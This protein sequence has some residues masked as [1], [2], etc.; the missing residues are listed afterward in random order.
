M[1][2][3]S[4]S[5]DRVTPSLASRKKKVKFSKPTS[6]PEISHGT[7]HTTAAGKPEALS[8]EANLFY[9]LREKAPSPPSNPLEAK[10]KSIRGRTPEDPTHP[11]GVFPLSGH[12]Q[13]TTSPSSPEKEEGE[14]TPSDADTPTVLLEHYWTLYRRSGLGVNSQLR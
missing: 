6:A 10:G 9:V 12:E 13:V 14:V 5:I 11:V 4:E 1:P 7:S 3:K 2:G 8:T